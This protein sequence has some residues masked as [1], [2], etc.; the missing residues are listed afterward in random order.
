V[1]SRTLKVK[2]RK[3]HNKGQSG[4]HREILARSEK[5]NG[6][7]EEYILDKIP[8]GE[9]SQLAPNWWARVSG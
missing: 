2:K 8:S 1:I 4:P 7:K 3:G 9:V 6:R 5:K